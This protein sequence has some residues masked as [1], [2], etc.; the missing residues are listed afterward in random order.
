M[1]LVECLPR[2][3]QTL[4]MCYSCLAPHALLGNQPYA[5]NIGVETIMIIL[6]APQASCLTPLMKEKL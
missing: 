6:L 5:G 4:L 3:F 1:K 2:W